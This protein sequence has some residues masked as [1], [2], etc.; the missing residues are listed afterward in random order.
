MSVFRRRVASWA[1]Y[2]LVV[3]AGAAG[4]V[5]IAWIWHRLS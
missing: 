4:G 2:A 1:P 5:G 3:A